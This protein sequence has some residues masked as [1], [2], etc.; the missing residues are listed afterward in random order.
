MTPLQKSFVPAAGA[1][2]KVEPPS[3][4]PTGEFAQRKVK[5]SGYFSDEDNS[6]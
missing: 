3:P 5:T 6:D 1:A 2:V 4:A